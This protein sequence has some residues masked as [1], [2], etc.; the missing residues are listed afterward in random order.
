MLS[1]AVMPVTV[2]A[3]PPSMAT[4]MSKSLT[5][6]FFTVTPLTWNSRMPVPSPGDGPP[7]TR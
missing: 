1:R 2:L 3:D 4:P 6:P 5:V 7:N